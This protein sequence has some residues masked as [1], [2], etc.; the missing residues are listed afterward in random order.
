MKRFTDLEKKYVLEALENEFQ[1]SKN[2]IYNRRLEDAFAAKFG[3]GFALGHVNGTATMHTALA[4]LGVQPGDEVIVPPLTMSSTSLAVLQNGSIPV[5]ADVDPQT[6]NIDAASIEANVTEKT[7]AVITVALFGLAPDYDAILEVCRKHKLFLIEDNAECFLGMYKGKPAGAFGHFS[8]YSFQASKHMTC[9][10]GGMLLTDDEELADRGRRFSTLGYANVSSK[11]GKISKEDI[12]SPNFDR[13]VALGFNYRMSEL[14]AAAALGQLERLDEL[15]GA[16]VNAAK[17]FDQVLDEEKVTYLRRQLEPK[18]YVNS[19]WAWS[20][21]LET[22]KPETDW[23]TFRKIFRGHGGDGYYA[24]WKLSYMEPYFKNDV[25][26]L[27]GVTQKYAAGLC[28]NAEF[29][30]PR[31]KQFK[32]NYW[33]PAEAEAQAEILR[34]TVREFSPE[35]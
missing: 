11:V 1:T 13:H 31:L 7:R 28:P 27:P 33:D 23:F 19:Y 30:Q 21:V 17:M 9:G 14:Q 3:V 20:V 5:Y 6:F 25:Q 8:S 35:G 15:V 16:R 12:Q 22:A 2:G 18:D 32:T 29:L 34:K 4:A 26:K 24:A 10:E